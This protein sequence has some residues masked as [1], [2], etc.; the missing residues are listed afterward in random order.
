MHAAP[1][2]AAVLQGRFLAVVQVLVAMLIVVVKPVGALGGREFL[3]IGLA[4][5]SPEEGQGAQTQPQHSQQQGDPHQCLYLGQ[6]QTPGISQIHS[7][8]S[9]QH[10]PRVLYAHIH[11]ILDPHTDI[12]RRSLVQDLRMHP[13]KEENVHC[14]PLFCAL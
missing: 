7:P 5:D 9:P 12:K 13:K 3:L 10:S 11:T 6:A 2:V 14:I 4:D 1:M 8:M